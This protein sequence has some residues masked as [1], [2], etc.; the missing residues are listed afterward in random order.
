MAKMKQPMQVTD[1]DSQRFLGRDAQ[2]MNILAGRIVAETVKTTLGPRGMDK[3]LVDSLGDVVITNDG[4]TILGEMDIAHPAAKMIVEVAKTQDDEV[5]DGTTTAVVLGGELLKNAQSLLD[6]NVHPTIITS[7]YKAAAEKAEEILDEIATEVGQDNE[8]VLIQAA[9]TA[10]TGKGAEKAKDTL[11]ILAVNAVKQI[12]KGKDKKYVNIDDIKIEKKEG[13]SVE[14]STL[15]QGILID[16]ERVHSGMPR[17]LKNA[18]IALLNSPMEI[19]ETETDAEIRITSP[20]QMQAFIDEEEKGLKKMVDNIASRGVNVIFCQKGIDDL[21]QHY[22]A[23]KGIF[24]IRRVKKSDMKRISKATDAKIITK[25]EDLS[26]EDLGYAG[27][28]EEK[29]VGKDKMTFVEEC[30]NPKAVSL[31]LRGGTEHVIDSVERALEDAIG[32]VA[33]IIKD[34]RIVAGGGAAEIELGKRLSEYADSVGGREQLAIKAFAEAMDIVPRTLAENAGLDPI[35]ILVDL[36]SAH[37][38][39]GNDVGLNVFNGKAEH[40][41]E[42]GVV[43]PLR[44]KSQA[45]KSSSEA[46]MMLLRIDDVI[47]ASELKGGGAPPGGMPPGGMPGGM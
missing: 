8:E 23:K 10:M 34:G 47:A 3:M 4:A 44:I 28:V 29:K 16:K 22:L 26:E 2:R 43:E 37:E 25:I 32:V 12:A 41:M 7:G 5:G 45:V 1:E 30:K 38:K 17:K 13:G 39:N 24:A 21:V 36:R 9:E 18:K 40:V 19:E 46:A 15:I 20:D 33:T 42:K 31:L 11:T 35:D 6:Q 14:D 27:L